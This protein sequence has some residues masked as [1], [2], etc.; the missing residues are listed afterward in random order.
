[1]PRPKFVPTPEQR[2]YVQ[3]MAA[4]GISHERIALCIGLRSPKTLRRHFR[5]ELDLGATKADARVGQT[6]FQM[7]TSGKNPAATM[8]WLRCRGWH[9]GGGNRARLIVMPPFIVTAEKEAA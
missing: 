5:E 9:E 6:M 8:F 2:H 3:S 7:A 1:M 4:F